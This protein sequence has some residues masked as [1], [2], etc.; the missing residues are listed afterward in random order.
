MPTKNENV[1][2]LKG[3]VQA[4]KHLLNDI[5][6]LAHLGRKGLTK[7][8]RSV[9]LLSDAGKLHCARAELLCGII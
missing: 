5:V 9:N 1:V 6:E 4:T 7:L 2:R 8:C 3:V